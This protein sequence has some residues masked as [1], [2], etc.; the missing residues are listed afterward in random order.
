MAALD[1][2]LQ[3]YRDFAITEREKGTYFERLGMALRRLWPRPMPSSC[4]VL[5]KACPW[6]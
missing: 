1:Q 4:P 2:I 3:S 6:C 5:P